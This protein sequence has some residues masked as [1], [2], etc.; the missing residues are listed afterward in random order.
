MASIVDPA[1]PKGWRR[2]DQ[3]V[4]RMIQGW[5]PYHPDKL[6]D[7]NLEPVVIEE[8]AVRRR[9]SRYIII[10]TLAFLV[11]SVT[12]PLDA[13]T[14][15]AGTVTVAGYR[16]AVQHPTGGVVTHVR[17]NEGSKVKQG[18]V[19]VT[20][21]PLETAATVAD[22]EQEYINLLVSESRA[23]AEMFGRDIMWD[24]KLA[25][26]NAQRVADA[27]AIQRQLYDKRKTQFR[28]QLRG[29][30]SQLAGLTGAISSHRVQLGTLSEELRNV[31]ALS[32]D[33]F[34]P[35]SQVNTTLRSKVDQ[36][37]ALQTAESDVGKIRAQMAEVQSQV[38]AE[39][40]KEL[41]EL[42]KNRETIS[43]KLQAARFNQSLSQIRAPVS[44]TVVNLKVFTEG[45]VI[46]S[47]EVLMEIVPQS[48]AL[49]VE[50]KVPPSAIDK[51]R[52]GQA[53]DL[54]FTSFNTTT[55][56]VVQGIVK[57][58]GVDKLKAK[59]GEELS[60]GE[61]YYL[62]QIETTQEGLKQLGDRRLQP[63]MPVDVLVK[64]GQRTF[65]SYI[66]KP[67]S[68]KLAGSFKE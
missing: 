40:A 37:A 48:G 62:A 29:L 23:R 12:M 66:L 25:G 6:T 41:A 19:L 49:I 28:E 46:G 59:P 53:T 21:N 56:P 34:V 7:R 11:W 27:E 15:M 42:Q 50:T 39:V 67:L 38:L 32:K 5:N 51:V 65:M 20:I 10:A 52:V 3:F 60:E 44:G 64:R 14:I 17:V 31:E 36:E 43:S 4:D 57:A 35:K 2:A 54:R 61:D 55:T 58:V 68:D 26:L 63:G 33:G 22:L 8:S 18:E 9:G 45:G 47:G 13:G 1:Q 16:K 24:P 30:Q